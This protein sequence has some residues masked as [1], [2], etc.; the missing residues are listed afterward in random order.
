MDRAVDEML[1]AV[2]TIS[3]LLLLLISDDRTAAKTIGTDI[4]VML[5]EFIAKNHD[6]LAA[7]RTASGVFGT[8]SLF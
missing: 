8:N 4:V 6:L 1:S 5:Q 3:E 7:P 2:N